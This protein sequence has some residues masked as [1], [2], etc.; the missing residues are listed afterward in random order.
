MGDE[1]SQELAIVIMVAVVLVVLL[2]LGLAAC[3]N[4]QV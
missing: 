4:A 3:M 2:F 1:T